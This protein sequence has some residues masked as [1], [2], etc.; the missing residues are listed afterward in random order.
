M[1]VNKLS[2][3]EWT[4]VIHFTTGGDYAHY[5]NRVPAV[6]VNNRGFF[7]ISSAVSGSKDYW[8]KFKFS[9]GR[10]YNI[11]IQQYKQNGKYWF[12]ITIDGSSIVNV[13]NTKPTNFSNVKLYTSDPWYPPFTSDFGTIS[14]LKIE[15]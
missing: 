10:Q 1:I 8:K 2:N 14:H 15:K 12:E 3:H 13:E 11:T 5:G 9:L 4:N 6:W 7:Q